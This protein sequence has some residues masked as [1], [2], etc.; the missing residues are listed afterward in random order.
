MKLGKPKQGNTNKDKE[1]RI[2]LKDL[3]KL[4]NENK[5]LGENKVENSQGNVLWTDESNSNTSE[6]KASP[7]VEAKYI[8]NSNELQDNFSLSKLSLESSSQTHN[9]KK[10]DKTIKKNLTKTNSGH[11]TKLNKAQRSNVPKDKRK[12]TPS[13]TLVD[14]PWDE[15]DI[16]VTKKDSVMDDIF[17][18]MAPTLSQTRKAPAKG[19]SMYSDALAVVTHTEVRGVCCHPKNRLFR[20]PQSDKTIEEI[21]Y[22]YGQ[23]VTKQLFY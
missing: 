6:M 9:T 13:Q 11:D 8:F 19:T 20:W 10:S 5:G 18:D 12:K 16:K 15:F 1:K 4:A 23:N 3:A 14:K 21:T 2:L 7:P 22:L 17:A